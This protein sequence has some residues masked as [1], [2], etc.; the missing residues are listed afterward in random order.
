ME[1]CFRAWPLKF[2]STNYILDIRRIFFIYVDF[3]QWCS[4]FDFRLL[5]DNWI[6]YMDF[7]SLLFFLYLISWH[8]GRE[9]ELQ[10]MISLIKPKKFIAIIS[11]ASAAIFAE[12]FSCPMQT[13]LD[14]VQQSSS[15]VFTI[16]ATKQGYFYGI[17]L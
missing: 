12:P 9:W 4:E 8:V 15:S 11:L 5:N 2:D 3:L 1:L 6:V 17:P 10:A 7:I 14:S 13:V 16:L